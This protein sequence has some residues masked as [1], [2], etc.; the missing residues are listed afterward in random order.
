MYHPIPATF[1]PSTVPTV[2][3][4]PYSLPL[5]YVTCWMRVSLLSSAD[6]VCGTFGSPKAVEQA[7]SVRHWPSGNGPAFWFDIGGSEYGVTG[8]R[9]LC[10]CGLG[11]AESSDPVLLSAQV[12]RV[13]EVV[14]PLTPLASSAALEDRKYSVPFSSWLY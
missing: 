7:G 12:T 3:S 11:V 4:A 6:S 5:T 10:N 8:T 2:S 9:V 13:F 1:R 14:P